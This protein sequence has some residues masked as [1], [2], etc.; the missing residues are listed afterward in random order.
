MQYMLTI[1][2]LD[3]EVAPMGT[4]PCYRIFSFFT[5]F[6]VEMENYFLAQEN[7]RVPGEKYV[8]DPDLYFEVIRKCSCTVE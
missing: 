5:Q 1:E 7:K 4:T 8:F 2:S 3:P 6:R